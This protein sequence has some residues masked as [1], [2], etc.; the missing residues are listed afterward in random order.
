VI[1]IKEYSN[2]NIDDIIDMILKIQ[3]DEYNI[4]ISRGSQPDLFSIRDFYQTG[5][6][7]FWI[8]EDGSEIIGTIA[9]KDIGYNYAALRKMFVKKEYRGSGKNIAQLLLEIVFQWARSRKIEKIF[10]GTTESF[11]AARKFYH[12]NGFYEISQNE[13]PESFPLMTVDSK[14]YVYEF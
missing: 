8:A 12:K 10:L 6:G 1:E 11:K 13:L 3:V 5:N 14:F 2:E 9:L 4:Q 7:N